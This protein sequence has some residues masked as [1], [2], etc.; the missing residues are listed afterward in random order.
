MLDYQRHINELVHK[1]SAQVV[2]TDEA[3]R[4]HFSQDIF[5]RSTVAAA[6]VR[7]GS[8]AELA[9][10]VGE[11]TDSG[12][13][14]FPRGGGASYTSGYV[15]TTE[16]GVVIDLKGLDSIV[17]IN[18]EDMYVTVEAGCTW[19]SLY[20]VLSKRGLRTPFWGSLSGLRATVGGSISQNAIFWGAGN[21][22]GSSESVLGLSVVLADGSIVQT[23][24][25]GHRNT[26]PFSRYFGPDMTGLFC[27]DC[28]ALGIKATITL[29]LMHERASHRYL[30]FEYQEYEGLVAAMS[31]LSRR[32][33]PAQMFATDPGLAKARAQRE[34]LVKD[35]RA[36]GGVLARSKSPLR[37]LVDGLKV[38]ASGRSSIVVDRY[39]LHLSIER[40][41]DAAA[42]AL[43]EQ[44]ID[45]CR[46][47]GGKQ[48][49]ASIPTVLRANPFNPLNNALGPS[50]ERWVP[51]HAII[52]H[53]QAQ[54]CM[55]AIYRVFNHYASEMKSLNISTGFLLTTVHRSEFVIEPLWFWPDAIESIHREIVEH[56]VRE[57]QETYPVNPEAR[58]LV[59]AMRAELI[60]L[61]SAMGATHLQI[62]RAYP[63]TETM[64]AE[65]VKLLRAIKSYLDPRRLMNPG[66]LGL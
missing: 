29:K 11:L 57:R 65:T 38:A 4:I 49:S 61:F 20:E 24:S 31:A 58:A 17:E 54:A 46:S 56:S 5:T 47:F 48:V 14:V 36:L 64:T 37:G 44:A 10:L 16:Q 52:P 27:C 43:A 66:A 32:D 7:P 34:S 6:V 22:G 59:E 3:E 60:T 45:L 55:S 23:G 13:A 25:G 12:L 33:I 50:G 18:E 39:S 42:K 62:G 2:I 53:S 40:E 8:V 26:K 1:Y 15:P 9:T 19:K 41:S 28:G 35:V 30:S 51:V 21:F 63:F